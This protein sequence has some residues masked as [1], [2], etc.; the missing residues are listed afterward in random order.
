MPSVTIC[1]TP[2][3]LGGLARSAR[4]D[5]GIGL[6]Q[7]APAANIGTR[8]LS[9]FE[10][11]KPTARLDKVMDALHAAGLYLAVVKCE[12]SGVTDSSEEKGLTEPFEG[13]SKL[14]GTEFPYD[15]SNRNMDEGVFIRKVLKEARF[16]DVLKT[17]SYFGMDRVSAEIPSLKQEKAIAKVVDMI[18]RI[19]MGMAMAMVE[20]NDTTS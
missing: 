15:W 2:E 11:G 8:F 14:L 9:E 10:R 13:Y 4:M 1:Q 5:E 6:R 17:I 19:Q 16:N 3:Q 20:R 7:A 12:K 18:A